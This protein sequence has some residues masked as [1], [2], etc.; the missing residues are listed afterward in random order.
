MSVLSND[1]DPGIVTD[2]EQY[3]SNSDGISVVFENTV[4][5]KF[6]IGLD[7]NSTESDA[8]YSVKPKKYLN[9]NVN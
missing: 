4:D 7:Y 6:A 1:R 8:K 9:E 3:D 2:L 5:H